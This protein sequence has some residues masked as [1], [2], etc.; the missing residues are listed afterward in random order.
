MPPRP[1][2]FADLD[3]RSETVAADLLAAAGVSHPPVDVVDLASPWPT[4]WATCSW[5]T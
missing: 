5:G 1:N 4:S 3:T 2:E